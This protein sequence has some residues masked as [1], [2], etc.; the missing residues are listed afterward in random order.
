MVP[1]Q[2]ADPHLQNGTVAGTHAELVS[3]AAELE[4]RDAAIAAA[5][6]AWMRPYPWAHE[7]PIRLLPDYR[8]RLAAA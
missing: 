6:D 7:I 8:E 5:H 2:A 1:P 4:R 3:L